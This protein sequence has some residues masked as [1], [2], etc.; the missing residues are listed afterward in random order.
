MLN[1]FYFLDHRGGI[2]LD[3]GTP[4]FEDDQLPSIDSGLQ[5]R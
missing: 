5:A 2:D 1:V 4:S 3:V